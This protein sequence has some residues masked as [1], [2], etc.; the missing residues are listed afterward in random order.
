MMSDLDEIDDLH[1]ALDGAVA[2]MGVD[3]L[4]VLVALARRLHLGRQ[5]YG[6]LRIGADRRDWDAELRD[7]LL[8][9]LIY[10]TVALLKAESPPPPERS[11]PQASQLMVG[12]A[13]ESH[14]D[15]DR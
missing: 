6:E 15:A 14:E 5:A 12:T 13:D 10:G 11:R 7:E 4:R 3:E 8:D 1:T 9:G 2:T